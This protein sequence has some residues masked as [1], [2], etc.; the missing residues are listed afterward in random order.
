MYNTYLISATVCYNVINE[1]TYAKGRA[2]IQMYRVVPNTKKMELWLV[3]LSSLHCILSVEL[4]KINNDRFR[5]VYNTFMLL[6]LQH[7]YATQFTTHLCY[8]VYNTFMLLYVY[9]VCFISDN[10]C[11]E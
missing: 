9:I 1:N 8:S 6:S 2:L 5:A 4:V 3:K 7:I 10:V 11:Q